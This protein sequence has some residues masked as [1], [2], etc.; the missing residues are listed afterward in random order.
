MWS[1]DIKGDMRVS[2]L[3]NNL[4]VRFTDYITGEPF[5]S[6][7]GDNKANETVE[8]LLEFSK[9]EGLK[10]ELKLISEEA[11]K[12]LDS[13]KF[14]IEED[15]DN[16]DY[17]IPMSTIMTYDTPKT[18]SKKRSVAGLIKSFK[19]ETKLLDI[20]DP[21]IQKKI[22]ELME[23]RNGNSE[24]ENESLA[25]SRLLVGYK[26]IDFLSIGIFLESDLVG[27]CFSQILNNGYATSH[28]W[29]V[30]IKISKS[31]YAYLM[32]EKAQL[33][34][35][36]GCRFINIEQDLGKEGLRKWKLSYDS[37]IYLKKYKVTIGR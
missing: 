37:N 30:N 36:M 35:N 26:E 31:L 13:A 25:V 33:L 12:T 10:A 32:Q 4:V 22:M 24:I 19:L 1:W 11:V 20:S 6:F 14:K 27:F 28:F 23:Q 5:F 34:N 7:L 21:W 2:Q 9:K 16:F 3:N 8:K 29:R 15:R 17:V 18:K